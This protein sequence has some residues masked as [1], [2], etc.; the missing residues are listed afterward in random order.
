MP[1]IYPACLSNLNRSGGHRATPA[2]HS[3]SKWKAVT[4]AKRAIAYGRVW[5]GRWSRRRLR[6]TSQ[7]HYDCSSAAAKAGSRPEDRRTLKETR[8]PARTHPTSTKH[9]ENFLSVYS[10]RGHKPTHRVTGKTVIKGVSWD[11]S[12]KCS[13]NAYSHVAVQKQKW[14]SINKQFAMIVNAA[15]CTDNAQK[16]MPTVW[17]NAAWGVMSSADGKLCRRRSEKGTLYNL[18]LDY[19][20]MLLQRTHRSSVCAP[21]SHPT[22]GCNILRVLL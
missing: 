16:L 21:C 13:M 8:H 6:R 19:K 18:K 7:F 1:D 4:L 2:V 20:M 22:H 17:R 11:K 5:S 14:F 9:K 12:I 15:V 10:Q 3:G